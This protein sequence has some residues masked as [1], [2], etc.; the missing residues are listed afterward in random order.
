MR[1]SSVMPL[2]RPTLAEQRAIAADRTVTLAVRMPES[3]KKAVEAK[4]AEKGL[5]MGALTRLALEKL[6]TE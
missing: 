3:L 1:R 2:G 4:A 5:S 6:L